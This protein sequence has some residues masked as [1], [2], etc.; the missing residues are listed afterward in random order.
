MRR[1]TREAP[2]LARHPPHRRALD[3]RSPELLTRSCQNPLSRTAALHRNQRPTAPMSPHLRV[4]RIVQL[5]PR[6][7]LI[8]PALAL[9]QSLPAA[10]PVVYMPS[11]PDQRAC[12][13]ANERQPENTQQIRLNDFSL[14][15]LVRSA[16]YLRRGE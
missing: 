3:D 5:D 11:P 13:A 16:W 4:N 10:A 12:R 14:V 9:L 1:L 15:C 7:A 8:L 2:S 6:V